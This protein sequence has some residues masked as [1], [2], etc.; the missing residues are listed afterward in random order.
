MSTTSFSWERLGVAPVL[1][2][3][4]KMTYL[5][6]SRPSPAVVEAMGVGA[7]TFVDMARAKQQ[8]AARLAEVTGAPAAWVVASAASGLVASV[9]GCIVGTDLAGI[10]SV[11]QVATRRRQVVLAAPHA[12]H[13]GAPMVQ[14]VR[15]GGGEPVLVGQA[16]KVRLAHYEA[17]LTAEVAAVLY[18]VSHHSGEGA[19]TLEEVVAVA[20]AAEVPVIVDAA[21]E[22][23]LQRYLAAGADLVVHSGHKAIGGPTSGLVLGATAA[24]AGVAAQDVGVS[25]SMK[26]GKET[27]AGLLVAVEEYCSVSTTD[28]PSLDAVLD[29]VVAALPVELRGLTD[30]VTDGTRPIPRLR[31]ILPSPAAAA[32]LVARLEAHHPSV[33]TRNHGVAAGQIQLDPRELSVDEAGELGTILTRI[34]PEVLA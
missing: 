13:F 17:A 18:V 31:L 11:P 21:A 28:A 8:V 4:G 19:P 27:L 15:L 3:A 24:V 5:G 25:R 23:D 30:R 32:E 22:V 16:N 33:R 10:E 9:A 2:A 20:H 34:L 26:V 1:N 14:L 7:R 12:V 29:A 6:S